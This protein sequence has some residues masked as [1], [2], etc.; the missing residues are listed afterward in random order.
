MTTVTP[1]MKRLQSSPLASQRRVTT[2]FAHYLPVKAA[3][4]LH[5][6][7]DFIGGFSRPSGVEP[8]S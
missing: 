5:M 1:C 6:Q 7:A 8:L 2:W 3:A 4:G